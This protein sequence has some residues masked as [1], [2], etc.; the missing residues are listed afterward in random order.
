[1]QS[2][3]LYI[4]WTLEDQ[5]FV[6]VFTDEKAAEQAFQAYGEFGCWQEEEIEIQG[7]L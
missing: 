5:D 4:V 7:D 6:N 2:V 3:K 1:M